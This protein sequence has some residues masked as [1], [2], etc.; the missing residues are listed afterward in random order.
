[1]RAWGVA[2]LVCLLWHGLAWGEDKPVYEA[3][4]DVKAP[5]VIHSVN[6]QFTDQSRENHVSGTV[7]IGL[8]VDEDGNPQEVQVKKGIEKDLDQN[9]VDAVKQWR[10][11]PG[12]KDAKPVRVRISIA[13]QFKRL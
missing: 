10:F 3:G 1:M 6:P 9:A 12:S 5:Q 2:L 13:I 7:L 4:G 8:I 11:K